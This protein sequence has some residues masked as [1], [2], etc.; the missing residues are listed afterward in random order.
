MENEFERGKESSSRNNKTTHLI[1]NVSH[2]FS[3]IKDYSCLLNWFRENPLTSYK[4]DIKNRGVS[5]KLCIKVNFDKTD[6]N[7]NLLVSRLEKLYSYFQ[8]KEEGHLNFTTAVIFI[9][10]NESM[11][12]GKKEIIYNTNK[13][14]IIFPNIITEYDSL[15]YRKIQDDVSACFNEIRHNK[16]R[17]RIPGSFKQNGL[18]NRKYIYACTFNPMTKQLCYF[19]NS[20]IYNQISEFPNDV[21]PHYLDQRNE[22]SIQNLIDSRLINITSW[23]GNLFYL[24]SLFFINGKESPLKINDELIQKSNQRIAKNISN[25]QEKINEKELEKSS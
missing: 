25:S 18:Q 9:D 10:S 16:N 17:F 11:I 22:F 8:S 12:N 15:Q 5:S 20:V 3:L 2:D 24:G 1:D 7:W 19:G 4:E 23:S 14:Q 21:S 13:I 6:G